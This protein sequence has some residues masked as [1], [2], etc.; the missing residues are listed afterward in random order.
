MA[1]MIAA[2]TAGKG[3]LVRAPAKINLS[4]RITGRR[5]DGYHTLVSH[6]QKVVCTMSCIWSW[7]ER[8]LSCAVRTANLLLVAITWLF[9][10]QSFFGNMLAQQVSPADLLA[11]A[12]S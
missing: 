9:G 2:M 6:M 12:W 10:P 3:L 8:T 1:A 4:L 7:E 5:P 11:C